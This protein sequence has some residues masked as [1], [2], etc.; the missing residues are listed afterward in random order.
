M[1]LRSYRSVIAP[2]QAIFYEGDEIPELKDK[3]LF[4]TVR[5]N[6]Y[7]LNIENNTKQIEEVQ[8][9]LKIYEDVISLA[10][11]PRGD[12]YY[13]GYGIY[14]LNSLN[15]SSKK[16]VLIPVE[17]MSSSSRINL[18][19]FQV[20]PD[21]NKVV[22]AIDATN[23][24]DPKG[25]PPP[26]FTIQVP[27]VL[28]GEISS[29]SVVDETQ[30]KDW[31]LNAES[32]FTVNSS[33]LN[34]TLVSVIIPDTISSSVQN[35]KAITTESVRPSISISNPKYSATIPSLPANA[36]VIV[37]GSAS[38]SESGIQKVEA[39]IDTFPFGDTFPFKDVNPVSPGNWSKWSIPLNLNNTGYN[40]ILAM[41][42]D[43]TGN[44]NWAEITINIL[45]QKATTT[46]IESSE[47]QKSRVAFVKPTFTDTAYVGNNG[48]AFYA[49]YP[50][51][52]MTRAA[53]NVTTDLEMIRD[54]KVLPEAPVAA[55]AKTELDAKLGSLDT[56]VKEYLIPFTE[57]VKK[58]APNSTVVLIGDEDVHDGYIFE[59][60]GSNVYDVIFLLH[61][62]YVTQAEYDNLKRYVSNGGTIV[63]IDSSVFYAEVL[64]D[65]NNDTIT[66]VKGHDW[67]FDGTAARKSVAER[68]YNETR[69]WV[70]SNFLI[71][72]IQDKVYFTNNPFNY[73][74]FEENYVNNPNATIILNYGAKFPDEYPYESH[75][76][77][78]IATYELNYGK[79]KV[80]MMGIYSQLVGDN[81]AFVRFF[82][83]TILPRAFATR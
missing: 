55:D 56:D 52:N 47:Q 66:L 16:Q 21:Q 54:V 79:G 78:T 51:Y 12:L 28:A 33:A 20:Y 7:A 69:Q 2:T 75:R 39:F 26:S 27:K 31:D 83:K 81:E 49:F 74:H 37:N 5:G 15:A 44:E 11:S 80:I 58:F 1:P 30:N 38:D 76:N 62:E 13:G 53:V 9:Q 46:T 60:D 34:D 8:I 73:T 14:Q 68:W 25:T 82:D 71:N 61:N 32:D 65:K 50:K 64:Y 18:D 48:S 10:Q 70:G 4:G 43:N 63:F 29:V 3:F 24:T 36:T 45:G 35:A 19:Y 57:H 42:T 67:E 22:M 77:S 41:A 72:D 17:V 6:I 59:E 23:H 40:R